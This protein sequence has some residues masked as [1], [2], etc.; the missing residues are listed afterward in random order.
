MA[1]ASPSSAMYCCTEASTCWKNW[2]VKS[3]DMATEMAWYDNI[4]SALFFCRLWVDN[5]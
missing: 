4:M 5:D 1:T 3:S 2:A